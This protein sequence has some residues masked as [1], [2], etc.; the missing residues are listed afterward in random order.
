M[1]CMCS[2]IKQ[3]DLSTWKIDTT[4]KP[5]ITIIKMFAGCL[6]LKDIKGIEKFS[7]VYKANAKDLFANKRF[8]IG[9]L[10]EDFYLLLQKLFLCFFLLL[11]KKG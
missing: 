4:N 6:M 1:F 3:L 9:K 2:S 10:N 5:Y 11:Q 7:G 8:P